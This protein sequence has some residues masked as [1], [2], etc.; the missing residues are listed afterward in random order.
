MAATIFVEQESGTT[1][2]HLHRHSG[3]SSGFSA[4]VTTYLD[5]WPADPR[6]D[7]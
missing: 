6:A 1:T 4:P 2:G 5:P 7:S 3:Y